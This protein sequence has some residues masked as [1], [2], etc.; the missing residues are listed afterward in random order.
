MS[1][2]NPTIDLNSF[3]NLDY[4]KKMF[5][6]YSLSANSVNVLTG[7]KN[8][9]LYFSHPNQLNDIVDGSMLL[10]DLRNLDQE[11]FAL[12][13]QGIYKHLGISNENFIKQYSNDELVKLYQESKNIGFHDIK[14]MLSFLHSFSKGILSLTRK[15]TNNLMWAHY[16]YDDGFLIELDIDFLLEKLEQDHE[17]TNCFIF[18]INYKKKLYTIDFSKYLK[19][20][21]NT[22]NMMQP[23]LYY[24]ST[25]YNDWKYEKEWRI[26]INRDKLGHSLN[27]L[28]FQTQLLRDKIVGQDVANKQD[29]FNTKS[30]KIEISREIISKVILGPYFFNNSYFS[31]IKS[32][33]NVISYRIK[34]ATEISKSDFEKLNYFILLITELK[35]NYN[36][37][38]EQIEIVTKTGK[39]DNTSLKRRVCYNIRIIKLNNF[40]LS[41]ER[42]RID[43]KND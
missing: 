30:R 2:N 1:K 35:K 12:I 10:W 23:I 36:N 26:L 21:N 13:L 11:Y 41:I 15:S 22:L 17:I 19:F 18:P 5:K 40:V 16:S 7:N 32:I 34:Q 28:D 14:L 33:D 31:E 27:K 3:K 4:P 8:P 37:R 29:I 6:H 43:L 38:I 25:K 39:K 9:Y 24:N 42:T 20:D